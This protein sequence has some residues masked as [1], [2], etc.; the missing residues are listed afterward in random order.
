MVDEKILGHAAGYNK[1]SEAEIDRR[2]GLSRVE[3][4]REEGYR[5]QQDEYTRQE[6]YFEDLTKR[7]SSLP[8]DSKIKLETLQL[9]TDGE[10]EIGAEAEQDLG[11][12]VHAV[13]KFIGEIIPPDAPAFELRVSGKLTPTESPIFEAPSASSS[14]PRPVYDKIYKDLPNL[15]L[16]QWNGAKLSVSLKFAVRETH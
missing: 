9:W 2:F 4:A 1:V 14:C 5:M 3:A 8:S 11:Q 10:I 16:S 15:P 12:S 7:L 6:Q 13:E